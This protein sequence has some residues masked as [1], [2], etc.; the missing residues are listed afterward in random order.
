[1]ATWL[2]LSGPW[3]VSKA[4]GGAVI[5]IVSTCHRNEASPTSLR[6]TEIS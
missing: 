5:E 2:P 3:W 1:M 6:R 4:A